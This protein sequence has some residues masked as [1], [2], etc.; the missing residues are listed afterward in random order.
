MYRLVRPLLFSLDPEHAHHFTL[1]LLSLPIASLLTPF[2]RFDT[3]QLAVE[4][5]GLTF[6]NCIGL[7]AGYDKNGI[8]LKGL[9]ALGFGHIEVGTITRQAQA[10]N[11]RPRIAERAEEHVPQRQVGIRRGGRVASHAIM[12]AAAP[13][14]IAGMITG[15]SRSGPIVPAGIMRSK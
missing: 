12:T 5:F 10:G 13:M 4:A 1:Q 7:A 14:T 8:A 3:P 11:P 15:P 6:R 2:F 9:A